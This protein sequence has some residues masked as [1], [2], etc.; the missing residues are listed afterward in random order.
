VYRIAEQ[1]AGPLV[2]RVN[3][4]VFLYPNLSIPVP[5][6]QMSTYGS[7]SSTLKLNSV[8]QIRICASRIQILLCTLGG[9]D[10]FLKDV[11]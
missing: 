2:Q 10:N 7:V 5:A 3:R 8:F 1:I 6:F 9:V 11:P 4:Q